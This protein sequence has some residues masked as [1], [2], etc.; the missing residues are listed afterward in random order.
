MTYIIIYNH[1]QVCCLGKIKHYC[2]RYQ[3]ISCITNF[4]ILKLLPTIYL[5]FFIRQNM[6]KNALSS[7][8]Y[9]GLKQVAAAKSACYRPSIAINGFGRIGKCLL[10]KSIEKN[11]NVTD[12]YNRNIVL[13]G[14]SVL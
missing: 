4:N 8:S 10:R 7:T 11:V 2:T 14:D 9:R 13:S 5:R 3:I 1:L 12:H 6:L